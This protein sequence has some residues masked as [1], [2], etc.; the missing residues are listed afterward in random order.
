MNRSLVYITLDPPYR[1]ADNAMTFC[2]EGWA[3]VDDE[4]APDVE[5]RLNGRPCDVQLKLRPQV[6]DHFPGMRV[7]GIQV[8]VNFAPLYQD[9]PAFS[10]LLNYLNGYHYGLVGL[11]EAIRQDNGCIKWCDALFKLDQA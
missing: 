7:N 10:E 6:R 5:V 1:L 8:E 11:Y 9:Q 4:I 3:E 2:F